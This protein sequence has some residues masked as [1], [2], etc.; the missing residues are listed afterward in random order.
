MWSPRSWSQAQ[1]ISNSFMTNWYTEAWKKS[2]AN[3]IAGDQKLLFM[4]KNVLFYFLHAILCPEHTNL[5]KKQSLI[6]HFA[7]VAKDGLFWLNVVTSPRLTC[8]VTR[9]RSTCIVTSHSSFVLVRANWRKGDLHWWITTVNIDF[10]TPGIHVLACKKTRPFCPAMSR[11][12]A[13]TDIVVL[14]CFGCN[15]MQGKDFNYP[16]YNI[17]VPYKR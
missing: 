14:S 15:I 8:D 9:T 12:R 1:T 11:T 7:I 17:S 6:T 3:H 4:V 16:D 2:L 10:S 13:S 5:L